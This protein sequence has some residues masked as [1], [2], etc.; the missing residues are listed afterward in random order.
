MSNKVAILG[1]GIA[2]LSA[3]HELVE[4][5][6]H[7]DVFEALPIP[8][9]KARSIDIPGS[10]TPGPDG[11]RPDLPGEHGFRFFP[12]FYRHVTD[13]MRRIP[14][15]NGRTVADNLV[16]TTRVQL[17]RFDRPPVEITNRFPRSI[18]DV[19]LILD[20]LAMI[21]R[22]DLGIPHDELAWFASRVWQIVT[23]CRQ[24]RD[25]EY[26]SID[27]WHFIGA[28]TRSD[29]YRKLLGHGITRSLVA[30][31]ADRAST[32]TIGDIFVQLIFDIVKPGPSTDR[33]LNGPTN[34]VWIEPWIAHLE[35]LGVRYHVGSPV[36]AMRCDAG[37]IISATIE[38]DGRRR[39]IVADHYVL[40]LPVEDLLPLLTPS[41]VSAEPALGRLSELAKSTAWM[42]GIQLF[43]TEDVPLVHG[44]TIYVDSP[45]AL[46]SVS[47]AQFWS[48]V[49]LAR[50]G[51]GQVKGIISICISEWDAKGLNGRTAKECTPAQLTE[52]V[53][54]QLKCSLNVGGREILRDEH[55][56]RWFLDPDVQLREGADDTNEAPLLVNH[57]GTWA[58]RPDAV[59]QI[60]NMFLAADYVRTHTDLATMEAANEAARR[61]VNGILNAAGSSAPPC[62]IWTLH[63]P[64]IFAPWRA[65][66]E[67]RYRHGLPWDDTIVNAALALV[68]GGQEALLA[69]ARSAGLPMSMV[70][71]NPGIAAADSASKMIDAVTTLMQGVVPLAALRAAE[72]E[73]SA[74]GMPGAT[75]PE[76]VMADAVRRVPGLP[77][78][79]QPTS[80]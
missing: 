60:P 44:H 47:Q 77:G 15:R 50:Y 12:R 53:W 73:V 41:L 39:E 64:E 10:G 79:P 5:G 28:E 37:R 30:A 54:Q 48:E 58:L 27:W 52:E 14:Y 36:V 18:A 4:R 23:S 40:A 9:G 45:W 80:W 46:T 69:L 71:M 25:E 21:F 56:Y 29:A 33:V 32:K 1:G 65:I 6:F 57:V 49:D 38:T 63:E 55:L 7:V 78:L 34:D 2:G 22:G 75:S 62:P 13:T 8:G 24:R 19:R 72:R 35:S 26:E 42:N 59:T 68:G 3:A 16:D 61:A 43:L 70:S 17:A 20:D 67:V 11:L 74:Q 66:D 76:S 51:N 31:K